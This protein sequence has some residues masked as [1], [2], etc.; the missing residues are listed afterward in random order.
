MTIAKKGGVLGL[1]LG[2]VLVLGLMLGMGL[3]AYADGETL[4]ITIA[5]QLENQDDPEWAGQLNDGDVSIAEG[6]YV[7]FNMSTQEPQAMNIFL[8]GEAVYTKPS[9]AVSAENVYCFTAGKNCKIKGGYENR[10]DWSENPSVYI[11]QDASNADNAKAASCEV[12]VDESARL[13]NSNA[14]AGMS[15]ASTAV[16]TVTSGSTVTS[17]G[18]FAAALTAWTD[19]TTLTLLQDVSTGDTVLVSSGTKT[20][21]LNGKTITLT[22]S[23]SVFAVTNRATFTLEGPGTV[24]GGKGSKEGTYDVGG[25]IMVN[26][27]T[28]IMNGG[29][30]SGNTIAGDNG[31]EGGGVWVGNGGSFTMNGGSITNNSG[32]GGGVGIG[33]N[34][35]NNGNPPGTFTMNGGSIS[36]N[37]GNGY[38]AG[39]RLNNGTFN[40]NGGSITGS[41]DKF[42]IR[43]D[44][45]RG[46]K[47]R[48]NLSGDIAIGTIRFDGGMKANVAGAI[49]NASPIT[50]YMDEARVFTGSSDTAF[51]EAGRFTSGLNGYVVLKNNDGQLYLGNEESYAISF[52]SN[53]GSGEMTNEYVVKDGKY[54]LPA[55][56]FTPPENKDF[57]AWGYVGKEY[58]AGDSI[59]SVSAPMTFTA[60]WQGK[61][62][63]S[64]TVTFKVVNGSWDDGTT[65]EKT[66]TLT[67]NEGDTLK[68]AADQIPVVGG[69]PDE[70]FEAGSWDMKPSTE[71]AIT[72]PTK[73]TYTYAKKEVVSYSCTEGSGAS[74]TKGS[75][76]PLTFVF[77]RNVDDEKTFEAFKGAKVD[78]ADVP[79]SAY[80]TASGSLILSMTTTYLETLSAGDHELTVVFEDGEA[81]ATFAVK[82]AENGGASSDS[83]KSNN[84]SK[85][86]TGKTGDTTPVMLI[87]AFAMLSVIMLLVSFT[88]TRKPVRG[89]HA[90]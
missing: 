55:C 62:T 78:G 26:G 60:I 80:A 10:F 79:D 2:L 64:T 5:D 36:G 46:M 89:K 68:L 39:V 71:T 45:D 59:E 1:A 29:T 12:V 11:T 18:D 63:V 4:V 19:G 21:E 82:A 24:T 65:E 35:W 58:N 54:S 53:G 81:T 14:G 40:M 48:F 9:E 28:F 22:G 44:Q 31:R 52:A 7:Q 43:V 13:R 72:E 49:T 30:I 50:V 87:A 73:Y 17:Y 34:G 41:G 32:A 6:A 74:W 86:S 27:G 84:S 61:G 42:D 69:K 20:F 8:N 33:V 37:E 25:G 67:G 3:T 47:N 83:S 75:S 51:N 23:G 57:K 77:K 76:D 66:V 15:A 56:R 88:R 16:A 38:A 70:G 90:R 85:S